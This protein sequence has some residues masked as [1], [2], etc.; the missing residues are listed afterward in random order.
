MAYLGGGVAGKL[1]E[2]KQG[3]KAKAFSKTMRHPYDNQ[4]A[5]KIDWVVKQAKLYENYHAP[6][7]NRFLRNARMY[8]H[9]DFGQWPASVV[10]KLRQQGR[11][12]PTFPVIPDKIESLIGSYL[13]NS[14]DIKF[15][16][17]DGS[18]DQLTQKVMGMYMSD[19][20]KMDWECSNILALLDSM[21]GVGYERFYISD[22]VDDFG[23]IAMESL[24]PRYVLT[25]PA[26]KSEYTRDLDD[27]F[28]WS[29]MT[30]TQ[31][32]DKYGKHSERLM[33]LYH[34]ERMEGIDYG[35]NW[36]ATPRYRDADEK[37]GSAHKVWEFN[38]VEKIDRWYEY[39]KKNNNFFPNTGFKNGSTEDRE[40]KVHYINIMGLGPDDICWRKQKEKIKKIC[41]CA[42]TLDAELMLKSGKD[43]IQTG[44]VNLYPLGI[45]YRGQYIGLVVDRLYDIQ[46]G[47]NKGEMNIQDIQQRAA[48]GAFFIDRGM[49]GDSSAIEDEI[50]K[51]WNDPAARL[52][53]DEGSTA[54]YPNGIQQ[55][56]SSPPTSDMFNNTDRYYDHADRFSKVS[57]AQDSRAESGQ[58]SGRLF[59][60]KFEAGQL[61]QIYP[62]KFWERHIKEIAEGWLQQAKVTYSGVKRSFSDP[63]TKQTID[64]NIPA[65]N[66]LTGEKAVIND[67]ASLPRMKVTISPS[68]KGLNLRLSK[69]EQMGQ[70][71][72]TVQPDPSLGLLKIIFTAEALKTMEF[73]DELKTEVDYAA[74][75]LKKR[76]ALRVEAES[77][78][79]EMQVMAGQGKKDQMAQQVGMQ[80]QPQQAI[81]QNASEREPDEEEIMEGTLLEEQPQP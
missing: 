2:M 3:N 63:E 70:L 6:N 52:I 64:I 72:E 77:Q 17:D 34:R 22:L 62:K 32:I 35:Y 50:R 69:R 75:L 56:P 66:K 29:M 12:P 4:P 79:L 16:A 30:A 18:L 21:I 42:P 26:W 43:L 28:T 73:S 40:V 25:S 48:K 44:G 13:S 51:N 41:A 74:A 67:I 80:E 54:R 9:L 61:Q 36:G 59:Q 14:Y 23:N 46:Q 33:E 55:V 7:L 53:V 15:E 37:W 31:I 19:K 10:D 65:I 58:E 11:R 49:F 81:P 78:Q 27:Y 8:W 1:Y 57:A 76:E 24:N 39:D 47:I 38:Y 60:M 68:Q 5:R 71:M 45:K 20:N